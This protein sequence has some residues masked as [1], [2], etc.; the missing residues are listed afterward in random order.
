MV[1]S[2]PP[3]PRRSHSI[4]FCSKSCCC[5]VLRNG[6]CFRGLQEGVADDGNSAIGSLRCHP[7]E[8]GQVRKV[9]RFLP[10][11][12]FQEY[13]RGCPG[14]EPHGAFAGHRLLGECQGAQG[15]CPY[16]AV[17][18]LHRKNRSGYVLEFYRAGAWGIGA[19]WVLMDGGITGKQF[20]VT[21]ARWPTKSADFVLGLLRNAEANADL[22]ALDT[23][24]LVVSHIQVNQAPKQRRRTYRAHG[25]VC[26]PF[27][28]GLPKTQGSLCT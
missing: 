8:R 3:S 21:R 17:Q 9:A 1:G 25:R 19:V 6:Y 24:K 10:P 7:Q 5:I 11:R 27:P 12:L 4:N 26:C 16:E 2:P 13:A 18:R 28:V 14:C 15:G 20:G 22:K 23:S